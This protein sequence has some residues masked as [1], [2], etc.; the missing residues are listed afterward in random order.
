MLGWINLQEAL[1]SGI[2]VPNEDKTAF[3]KEVI[4]KLLDFIYENWGPLGDCNGIV[5]P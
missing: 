5:F 4:Y 3:Y 1:I 2:Y